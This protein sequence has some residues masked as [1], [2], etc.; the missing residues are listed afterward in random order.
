MK[1]VT[2]PGGPDFPAATFDDD[3]GTLLQFLSTILLYAGDVAATY[4]RANELVPKLQ[5]WKREY[6]NSSTR[7]VASASERLV[8]QIQGG[9]AQM[10][11]T[12]MRSTMNAHLICGVASCGINGPDRLTTCSSCH[13]QHYCGRDH[14]RADWKHHKHIC[15][16]GLV[17]EEPTAAATE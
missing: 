8:E 2:R 14:Q 4:P 11:G 13:L 6:R 5:V 10:M 1:G 17:E 7:P 3:I 9:L 16:K 12:M 15:N